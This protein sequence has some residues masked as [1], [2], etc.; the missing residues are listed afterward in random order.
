[1]IGVNIA[2]HLHE[3]PAV[4]GAPLSRPPPNTHWLY[5]RA[6]QL[7]NV[8]YVYMC[9]FIKVMQLII[10][11]IN[12]MQFF[13]TIVQVVQTFHCPIPEHF[14]QLQIKPH[15]CEQSFPTPNPRQLLYFL[16]LWICLF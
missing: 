15:P 2:P 8:C 5:K 3:W 4:I 6:A 16:L 11:L 13:F 10:K 1:M 14:H 9:M 7:R 12:F